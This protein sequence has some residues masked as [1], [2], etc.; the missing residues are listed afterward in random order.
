MAPGESDDVV[1]TAVPIQGAQFTVQ[2][3]Y[4]QGSNYV[5]GT[6]SLSP[7]LVKQPPQAPL[8]WVGN[9]TLGIGDNKIVI[10]VENPSPIPISDVVLTIDQYSGFTL[11]GPT[12]YELGGYLGPGQSAT[13]DIPI[14]VPVSSTSAGLSYSLSYVTGNGQS[15]EQGSLTFS[16]ISPSNVVISSVVISP[17][18]PPGIDSPITLSL[19]FINTGIDSIYDV[20]ASVKS[21]MAYISQPSTFYGEI[22]PQTPPTAGGVHFP[23]EQARRSLH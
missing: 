23:D 8:V 6:L 5:Q 7:P 9:N 3:S 21:D 19:T 15:A 1:L 10:T 17:P 22:S 14:L 2:Y 12:A 11:I 4:V 20:N 16:V 13:A 18:T